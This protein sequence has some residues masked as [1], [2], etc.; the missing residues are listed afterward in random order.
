MDYRNLEKFLR[1]VDLLARKGGATISGLERARGLS[2]RSVYRMFE[3][4]EELNFPI[5]DDKRPLEREKRWM[6]DEDYVAKLPNV[7]LPTLS[8]S[9]EESLLLSY[10][11][12]GRRP[13]MHSE[14]GKKIDALAAKLSLFG[15]EAASGNGFAGKF[16]SIF[17]STDRC[18]KDYAGKRRSSRR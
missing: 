5:Y 6:L 16:D 9:A 2:R 8:L 15:K 17:V 13:L 3:L 10:L 7:N 14:L 4:L 1:A 11:L 12:S 18:T